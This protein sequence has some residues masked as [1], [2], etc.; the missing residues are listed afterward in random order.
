MLVRVEIVAV[1]SWSFFQEPKRGWTFTVRR[2]DGTKLAEP[3]AKTAQRQ[4]QTGPGQIRASAPGLAT[5]S[6]RTHA[7]SHTCSAR[8]TPGG[9]PFGAGGLSVHPPHHNTNASPAFSPRGLSNVGVLLA[10]SRRYQHPR[11]L[12]SFAAP[13][14]ASTST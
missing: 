12:Y 11:F 6:H 5:F 2:G 8:S 13:L 10:C 3:R 9:A 1:P 7:H 14:C 4:L